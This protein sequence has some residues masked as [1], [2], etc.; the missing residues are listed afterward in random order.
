MDYEGKTKAALHEVLDGRGITY[1][2]KDTKAV[3]VQLCVD[4]EPAPEKKVVDYTN[5]ETIARAKTLA[6]TLRSIASEVRGKSG[7][8]LEEAK[9]RALSKLQ[10]GSSQASEQEIKK[11]WDN[12][13]SP[14]KAR[15]KALKQARRSRRKKMAKESRRA[16]R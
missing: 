11:H 3:L 7:E 10:Q 12:H 16:N 8:D 13:A 4:S 2:K 1:R 9:A 14:Q 15:E 6:D 5:E